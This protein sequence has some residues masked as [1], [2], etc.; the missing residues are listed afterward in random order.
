MDCFCLNFILPL[1]NMLMDPLWVAKA[2]AFRSTFKIAL[3]ARSTKILNS[4][5]LLKQIRI[6]WH[7]TIK[8]KLDKFGPEKIS[9]VQISF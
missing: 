8:I 5:V 4:P 2:F 6:A 1:L 3:K 9:M 7:K